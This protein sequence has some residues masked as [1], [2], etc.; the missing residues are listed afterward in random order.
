M[1]HHYSMVSGGFASLGSFFG[2][3]ISYEVSENRMFCGVV[4]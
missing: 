1:K 2:K 4:V 3:L